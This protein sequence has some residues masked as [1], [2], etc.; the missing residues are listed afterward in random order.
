MAK[1]LIEHLTKRFG[2]TVAVN[3]LNLEVRDREF[4]CL[5]GPSGCGKTTTLRCIAGLERQ[6]EGNIYIGDVLVNDLPPPERDIAMVFQFYAIYPGMTVYDNL[7]FPLKQRK[8]SKSEIRKKVLETAKMLRIENILNEDAISRTAGEKQR[9]ALGRAFV[10]DPQVF[11]LDEPL[12]NLD[13]GLRAVM[14]VELKRLHREMGRTTIYVTH[15]QLEGMTMADRIGVMNYGVLQQ[16]DDPHTLF[17]K[18]KNLFVA[19]FIGT[20]TMN[21]LEC[22]Y[23]ERHGKALLIF[24]SFSLDVSKYKEVI[25]KGKRSSSMI[26]GVRPSDITVQKERG[27]EDQFVEA[28]VDIIELTGDEKILDLDIGGDIVRAIA[29]RRFPVEVGEKVWLR[30]DLD[31][32]HIFDKKTEEAIL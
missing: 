12:T 17:N 29:K 25:D 9:I 32:L 21:F 2:K 23:E 5:L 10:R 31:R 18:P 15:D 20:P 16:Y 26:L 24:N 8:M 6:D 13:A 28:K 4:V 1:V 30:L 3:N 27:N 11:L 22:E 19:G 7:A 14:R